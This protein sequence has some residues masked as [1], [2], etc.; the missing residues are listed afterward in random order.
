MAL[1]VAAVA[2]RRFDF[3]LA[4]YRLAEIHNL[5]GEEGPTEDL[6]AKARAILVPLAR[7]P[8]SPLSLHEVTTC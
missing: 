3:A 6:Y 5:L 4:T 8:S 7:E 2:G 1:R